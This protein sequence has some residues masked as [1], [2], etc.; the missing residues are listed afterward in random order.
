MHAC[1]SFR[2]NIMTFNISLVA[3]PTA[4]MNTTS[5][6]SIEHE[7]THTWTIL[8]IYYYDDDYYGLL[9]AGA[10]ETCE[11]MSCQ[12]DVFDIFV[13][14]ITTAPQHIPSLQPNSINEDDVY[15]KLIFKTI[16][17]EHNPTPYTFGMSMSTAVGSI[18]SESVSNNPFGQIMGN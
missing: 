11:R 3:K 10:M 14:M 5:E 9:C 7:H 6:L 15:R 4:K 13:Y 17:H 1:R 16:L 2:S 18:E 8:L 12:C